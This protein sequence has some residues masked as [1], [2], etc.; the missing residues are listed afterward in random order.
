MGKNP[1]N[2]STSRVSLAGLFR[3]LLS[4]NKNYKNFSKAQAVSISS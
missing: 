3:S 1:Y 2:G 4:L